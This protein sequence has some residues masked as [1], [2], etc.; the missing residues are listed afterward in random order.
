LRGVKILNNL[1]ISNLDEEMCTDSGEI[2]GWRIEI[3]S[4][5]NKLANQRGG[6]SEAHRKVRDESYKLLNEKTGA[7]LEVRLINKRKKVLKETG[8]KSKAGRVSKLEVIAENKR[9]KEVYIV[10]VRD[11]AKRY[12]VI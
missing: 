5:L 6:T 7:K 4:L 1:T 11:M 10:V 2:A 8:S 3:N 9:L 12:K